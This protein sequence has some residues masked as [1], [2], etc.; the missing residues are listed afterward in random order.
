MPD[1]VEKE[2]VRGVTTPMDIVKGVSKSLA[3]AALVAKVD[4]QVWDLF[5]PLEGD[6]ALQVLGFD[7]PEGREVRITD[8]SAHL[9][10]P[11]WRTQ[12]RR[13]STRRSLDADG[14]MRLPCC[15]PY[16]TRMH[17]THVPPAGVCSVRRRFSGGAQKCECICMRQTFWHSSAHVLG[18]ALEACFG[19]RLTIGPAVEEGFYYD[20]YMGD[21]T[22]TDAEKPVLEKKIEQVLSLISK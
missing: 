1:G 12:L 10:V 21:R 17:A 22:L 20:C 8:T 19:V 11:T 2:G 13:T 18:E 16:P 7:D 15:Q 3:N 5:R 6:C 9:S 14:C 4:G